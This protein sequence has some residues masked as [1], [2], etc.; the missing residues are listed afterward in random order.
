MAGERNPSAKYPRILLKLSGEALAARPAS[1][2]ISRCCVSW[3]MRL[4]APVSLGVQLALVVG[5]GNFIRGGQLSALGFDRVV[6]DRMGMLATVLNALAVA[7]SCSARGVPALTL[8]A[9]AIQ[10]L[11]E[12]YR[13]EI[14]CEASRAGQGRG[15][16][17]WDGE[18]ILFN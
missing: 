8:S 14:A 5:G 9:V 17:R 3:P 2:S 12:P 16:G 13:R 18:S 4:L 11:I 6:G 7:Q 10:G 15:V 1:G